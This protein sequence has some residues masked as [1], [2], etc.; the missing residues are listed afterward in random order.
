MVSCVFL[1][2][3]LD[4]STIVAYAHRAGLSP[5][6]T[7][8]IGFDRRDWDESRD[9]RLVAERFGAD[10][11]VLRLREHDLAA[12]LPATVETLVRHHD[13]P[14]GDS[15]ALPTFHVSRLAREHVTVI[16]GGDGGDELFA[17]YSSYR[18]ARFAELYRRLPAWLA[19][20]LLP[21]SAL[22]IASAAPPGLRYG[23]QRVA[24]VLRDSAL[25][26]D[27]MY[28]SK[29]A[30]CSRDVLARVLDHDMAALDDIDAPA[31][32]GDVEAVLRS[33]LPA[34][35]K[36]GYA[37][38]RFGLLNAMLVKVDRMS[39]ANS[40]EVRSPLLDHR[41][42]EYVAALPPELKLRN[43][44]TK[45]ILRDVVKDV[46]P[47]RTMAKR[48]QGFAVPLRE[49]LRD[50]LSEMVGDYLEAADA[51]LPDALNRAAV[52]D[53][54]AEHRRGTADHSRVIW[55]L[56]THAAWHELYVRRCPVPAAS[57]TARPRALPRRS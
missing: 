13:Q 9:A 33:S 17:G 2:G 31:R 15:S 35:T 50:G 28:F 1:S 49:W 45:A 18:G 32:G 22:A 23:P 20:K 8:T 27:E 11:H 16:L 29:A 36:A 38:I 6:K 12:D 40:L 5:L 4:S 7:F 46:L 48:K 24:K 10:H 30:L 51:R 26:F 52:R 37:D 3:G 39:M 56:L 34:V 25:P 41:L 55:L 47:P 57:R 21:E 53:V 44:E 43:W 14:F 19:A 42:V 54:L